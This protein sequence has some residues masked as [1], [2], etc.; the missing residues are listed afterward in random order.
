MTATALRHAQAAGLQSVFEAQRTTPN[1]LHG[2][3]ADAEAAAGAADLLSAA[4]QDATYQ[5]QLPRTA[6]EQNPDTTG[7]GEAKSGP[8][9]Q[10]PCSRT[11]TGPDPRS[12]APT[13]WFAVDQ[14]DFLFAAT[15]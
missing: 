14:N 6:P 13:E 8:A 11:A 2:V 4:G 1:C 5:K 15:H 9:P 7:Q 12:A 10:P 3:T